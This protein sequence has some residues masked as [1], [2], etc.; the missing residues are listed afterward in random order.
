M[1]KIVGFTGTQGSGKTTQLELTKKRPNHALTDNV[2]VYNNTT[3]R[4]IVKQMGISF[5]QSYYSNPEL[6]AGFQTR[7]LID[8]VDFDIQRIS[9]LVTR[10]KKVALTDR[11]YMDLHAYTIAN[12][13]MYPEYEEFL[14][15]YGNVCEL[16]ASQVYDGIVLFP[17]PNFN[18][19]IQD[20][21]RPA[22]PHYQRTVSAI[23][24]SLIPQ[25][26]R[27]VVCLNNTKQKPPQI[28]NDEVV[29]TVMNVSD[30]IFTLQQKLTTLQ[31]L[32]MMITSNPIFNITQGK[33]ND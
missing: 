5:N 14:T 33:T 12:L 8:M 1:T 30:S 10:D 4:D 11:T 2:V 9:E 20:G 24:R 6:V 23:L 26:S 18:V 3:S 7:V 28:I 15:N 16:L 29:S 32:K 22:S 27:L 13:S 21:V 25:Y 31:G 19:N 17:Q